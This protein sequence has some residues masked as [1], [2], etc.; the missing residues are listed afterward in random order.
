MSRFTC[1]RLL[2]LAL[3]ACSLVAGEIGM[4]SR[5]SVIRTPNGGTPAEAA[6]GRMA[7]ST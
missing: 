5:V 4:Q 3:C 7:T 1:Y 2:A 6:R